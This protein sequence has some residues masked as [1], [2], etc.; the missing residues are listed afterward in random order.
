[1]WDLRQPTPKRGNDPPIKE[2]SIK[3]HIGSSYYFQSK[4]FEVIADGLCSSAKAGDASCDSFYSPGMTR[5]NPMTASERKQND[6]QCERSG[7]LLFPQIEDN[8]KIVARENLLCIKG[9]NGSDEGPSG[10]PIDKRCKY[11]FVDQPSTRTLITA[12]RTFHAKVVLR[13]RSPVA[14]EWRTVVDGEA[15][16]SGAWGGGGA[17]RGG[18]KG[19]VGGGGGGGGRGCRRWGESGQEVVLGGGCWGRREREEFAEDES[20]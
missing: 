1:M 7:D 15:G 9:P 20:G 17:A 6:P 18:E 16:R 5:K 13:Q 8:P 4:P 11:T 12:A 3:L 2:H 14:G 19:M 10:E